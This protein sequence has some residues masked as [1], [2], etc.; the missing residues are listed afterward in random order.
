MANSDSQK[1]LLIIL[2]ILLPPVAV[3]LKKGAGTDLLLNIVLTILFFI[4]GVLHALYVIL[5]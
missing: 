1:I 5:K 4:P 2:A 3:F